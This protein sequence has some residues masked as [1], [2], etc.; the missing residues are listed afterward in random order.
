VPRERSDGAEHAPDLELQ[1]DLAEVIFDA[2]SLHDMAPVL[3]QM[4]VGRLG[5]AAAELWIQRGKGA[6][7]SPG[8]HW[9][10]RAVHDAV[11][12]SSSPE[13]DRSRAEGPNGHVPLPDSES[14]TPPTDLYCSSEQAC[15]LD[16]ERRAILRTYS[17][18]PRE[19]PVATQRFLRYLGR[20]IA[21]SIEAR[22]Q[23]ERFE[24]MA[25]RQA[26]LL[27]AARDAAFTIDARGRVLTLNSTAE[28]LFGLGPSAVGSDLVDLL[29]AP[30]QRKDVRAAI[31]HFRAARGRE[32]RG[33]DV[34][35]CAVRSDHSEF[36]AQF[37]LAR[38]DP[39]GVLPLTVLVTDVSRRNANDRRLQA[40]QDRLRSLTADLLLAEERAR[41]ELALDLHDGLSQTIAL[42]KMRVVSL[43]AGT[44]NAQ[45]AALDE[46]EL[47]ID[48][49][50]RAA[51][52]V[53]FEL[54]PPLLH[55][56]GLEPALEW[57]AENIGARYGLQVVLVHDN[58][59]KPTD[60]KTRIILFRSIR[61]LLINAA[62]HAKAAVV[63][64]ALERIGN[65]LQVSVDD[66]GVGMA[67]GLEDVQGFGLFSIRE[68]LRHVGGDMSIVSEPGRGTS[69]QL[70][71]PTDD[72][73]QHASGPRS[74]EP[75]P[76]IGS[77]MRLESRSS[78]LGTS[79]GEKS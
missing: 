56:L 46:V 53:S 45:A 47:L 31:H 64:V 73:A 65:E 54:S 10:V 18:E 71:A 78:G 29:V 48:Q 27:D 13:E 62:K 4:L 77:D 51:R 58:R 74:E 2:G 32:A 69:V 22:A 7:V 34:E 49:A 14:H 44:T 28:V 61:E 12:E 72:Q 52:S 24:V 63:T 42:I 70:R 36:A 60:E 19:L 37:G 41:R 30:K 25:A 16:A 6:D 11:P 8:M 57:L 17:A 33:R 3:L 68:R 5:L 50:N 59:P 20:Q 9:I 43:R 21:R 1:Y 35:A 40:Y 55:D 23:A 67:L 66:D 38:M 79:Q 39:S 76:C 26:V 75:D 15:T